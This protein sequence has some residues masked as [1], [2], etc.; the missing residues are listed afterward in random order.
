MNELQILLQRMIDLKASDLHLSHMNKITYRIDGIV[1]QIGQII[2]GDE[3]FEICL[4][5]LHSEQQRQFLDTGSVDFAYQFIDKEGKVARFRGIMVRAREETTAVFRRINSEIVTIEELGLPKILKQLADSSWGLV[6][7][8]GPTGSGKTTSLASIVDYINENKT[9]HIATIEQPIEYIHK[10]KNSIITQREIPSD[11][12][13][14]ADSM[15]D[16]LRQDPDV[17]LVG[18]MRDLE[19]I[20]AAITNAETGHLVFGTLHTNTAPHAINRIVDVYPVEQHHNI[21]SQLA[22]NLR[23]IVAQRLFPKPGGGR[24]ALF[25]IMVLN[26]EMRALIREGKV[27]NLYDVMRRHKDDGNILMEDSIKVAKEQGLLFDNVTW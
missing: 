12:A 4:Y 8:T 3:I 18:E 7:F 16:V 27:E 5:A 10:N 1:Q 14:F 21:R 13:S 15:K 22:S 24:T 23:A 25:E 20:S 2:S 11:S 6:L 19:T 26:E 9:L 17:I